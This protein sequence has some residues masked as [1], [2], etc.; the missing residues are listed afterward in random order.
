MDYGALLRRAWD[1]VWHNKW[2]IILGLIVSLTSG[3]WG[4]GGG[5]SGFDFDNGDNG[6]NYNYDFNEEFGDDFNFDEDFTDNLPL[7]GGLAMAVLIPIA[8]LL[9][10]IGIA[11]W[12]A[13]VIAR[14]GLVVAAD[15]LDAGG[16]SSFSTAWHAGWE[17]GWRLIGIAI[18]PAIPMLILLGIGI[19][20]GGALYG[21]IGMRGDIFAGSF[22]PLGITFVALACIAG[23]A[24]FVLGLLQ[25]FAER[26]AMLEDTTV[27]GSYGR[28]WEVLSSN[29]GPALVVF[30]IQTAIGILIFIGAIVLSPLLICLCLLVIP[31]ALLIGGLKEAYF[32]TLWTL[33]WRQW[34][35]RSGMVSGEP[36]VVETPPA[37]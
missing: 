7:V 15:T 34:T 20:V 28:G 29:L 35:G 3:G 37:V 21:V 26:A 23:L 1:L 36:V 22:G 18:F 31:L 2:L 32:S 16:T 5:N 6:Q 4:G 14:G 17:K 27:F 12:A 11:L 10:L 13:G 8:C 19:A 25:T 24:A 30:L 33:A 9:S